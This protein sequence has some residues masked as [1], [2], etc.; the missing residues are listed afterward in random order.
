MK[1]IFKKKKL[2]SFSKSSFKIKKNIQG[3][4]Y[5][6]LNKDSKIYH[7]FGELYITTLN[8]NVSKGWIYH[9]KMTSNVFVVKG[10]VKFFLKNNN[11]TT[12]KILSENRN[13]ILTIKPKVWFKIVNLVNKTSKIINFASL[14]HNPNEV[15][16]KENL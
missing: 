8:I 11:Y 13:E 6:I 16:K 9:K 10:K 3:N 4:V 14:K 12:K 2:S 15:I 7:G 1:R 5:K